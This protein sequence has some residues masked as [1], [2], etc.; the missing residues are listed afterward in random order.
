MPIDQ[1]LS[2]RPVEQKDLV[3][4]V[5]RE[6]RPLLGKIRDAL[7]SRIG[8]STE[9][10]GDYAV[11][12]LIETI[13]CDTTSGSLAIF[14]PPSAQWT[15]ELTIIKQSGGPN[16]VNITPLDTETVSGSS[17]LT[18]TTQYNGYRI[19]PILGQWYIVGVIA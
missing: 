9:V 3:D 4:Y 14:L 1:Q 5:N 13:L 7:V 19:R 10:F 15:R 17:P 11:T 6:L 12:G 16:A 2:A 18:I 8:L